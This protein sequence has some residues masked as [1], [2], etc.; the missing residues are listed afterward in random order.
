MIIFES[1]KKRKIFIQLIPAFIL[2][3]FFSIYSLSLAEDTKFVEGYCG[4]FGREAR[5]IHL[6]I[7]YN[8][9]NINLTIHSIPSSD[10]TFIDWGNYDVYVKNIEKENYRY[11]KSEF[12]SWGP[13]S[14]QYLSQKRKQAEEKQKAE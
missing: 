13:K 14:K 7:K 11:Y 10:M 2:F 4:G 3:S 8:G 9:E 5:V 6:S 1:L 12:V